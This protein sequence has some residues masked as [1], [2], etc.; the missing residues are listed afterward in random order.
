MLLF[1]RT[2][3]LSLEETLLTQLKRSVIAFLNLEKKCPLEF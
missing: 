2:R 3:N 1:D